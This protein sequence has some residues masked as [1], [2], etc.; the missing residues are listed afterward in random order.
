VKDITLNLDGR[1]FAVVGATSS[2]VDG[3][4]PT[5]FLH[6]EA[7]GVVW[8]TYAGDTI[9]LGRVA[10]VRRHDKLDVGYVQV[11][12]ADQVTMAGRSSGRIEVLADGRLRL[13]EHYTFEEDGTR[14]VSICEELRQEP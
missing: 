8:A 14:H 3:D 12:K 9:L 6:H 1:R 5:E 10:G 11:R 2:V 13:I 7:G 4:A